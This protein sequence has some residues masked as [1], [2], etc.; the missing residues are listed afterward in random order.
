MTTKLWPSYLAPEQLSRVYRRNSHCTPDEN[1]EMTSLVEV[2]ETL[3]QSLSKVWLCSPCRKKRGIKF[4]QETR[5]HFLAWRN[6]DRATRL[7]GASLTQEMNADT[8]KLPQR[9]KQLFSNT[10]K[11]L[12]IGRRTNIENFRQGSLSI[13]SEDDYHLP[14]LHSQLIVQTPA[15]VGH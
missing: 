5:G 1:H 13:N 2:I 10:T 8:V 15:G 11:T 12:D 7:T 14:N 9:S 3:G 4:P 6:C